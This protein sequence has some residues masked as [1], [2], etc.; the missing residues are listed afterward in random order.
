MILSAVRGRTVRVGVAQ[1]EAGAPSAPGSAPEASGA[2]ARMNLPGATRA[3]K[4]SDTGAPA[5]KSDC[6]CEHITFPAHTHTRGY[7]I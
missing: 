6:D 2:G 5:L 1:R 4:R 7:P 3:F